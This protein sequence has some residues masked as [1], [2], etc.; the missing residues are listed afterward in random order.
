MKNFMKYIYIIGI[1]WLMSFWSQNVSAQ[2]TCPSGQHWS[3]WSCVADFTNIPVNN[4]T[5]TTNW[6]GPD[7]YYRNGMWA[8]S[9]PCFPKLC[10]WHSNWYCMDMRAGV[11]E[12]KAKEKECLWWYN[13]KWYKQRWDADFCKC[14]SQW[15]TELAVAIPFVGG[16]ANPDWSINKSDRCVPKSASGSA[17]PL[18]IWVIIQILNTLLLVWWFAM[19]VYAGVLYTMQDIKW[20]KKIMRWV[21]GAFA[22]YWSLGLLLKLIN[23]TLFT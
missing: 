22:L 9:D 19:F 4:S 13:E 20:A 2:W 8:Q 21:I 15:W 1:F 23:P 18:L 3:N 14:V 10:I 7:K 12:V 17:L 11:S 5:S 16:S 6:C